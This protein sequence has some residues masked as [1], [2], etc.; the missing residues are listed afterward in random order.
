[1]SP[2]TP[3]VERALALAATQYGLLTAKQCREAGVSRNTVQRLVRQGAW[4][5]EAPGVYRLADAPRTWR[6]RALSAALVCGPGAVVSHRSAAHL[7]GLAGFWPTDLISVTVARHRRPRPRPG[8]EVHET[9][10]TGLLGATV[11]LGVPITGPE[12][13]FLDLAAIGAEDDELVRAR[14]EIV[15]LRL[16]TPV[17][18]WAALAAHRGPGRRGLGEARAVLLRALRR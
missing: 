13:T 10:R 16:A 8:I 11:H 12:R 15:R 5:P 4:T 18:L 3:A 9:A 2:I 17:D 1:M 14:A 7:W 6:G